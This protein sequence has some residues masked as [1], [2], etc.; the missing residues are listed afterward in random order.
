MGKDTG[1]TGL[2]PADFMPMHQ[3]Q[4]VYFPYL[5]MGELD[6]IDLGFLKVWNFDLKK[7]IYVK[8]AT[9]LA[10]VEKIIATHVTQYGN[11]KGIGI[12]QMP[13]KGFEP[14]NDDEIELV[15]QARAILFLMATSANN[16]KIADGNSGHSM[17]TSENFDAIYQNFL[18]TDDYVS[19]SAGE[20][21]PFRKGGNTLQKIR[22][23]IPNFVPT[24]HRYGLDQEMQVALSRIRSKKPKVFQRIINSTQIFIEGYYNSPH[25]SSKA[26]VLMIMS[27]FEMIFS[28][29][30]QDMRKHF[31]NKIQSIA[32]LDGDKR[33]MNYWKSRA[34]PKSKESLSKKGL[35]AEKFYLL[36]NKITHGDDVTK[37][38]FFFEKKQPHIYIAL[39]FFILAIKKQF[40]KSLND[41]TCNYEIKW[42]TYLDEISFDQ[43]RKVTK[44]VYK[45]SRRKLFQKLLGK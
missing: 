7:D 33:Y 34:Y 1:S 3:Y 44:F 35:W 22:F 2:E 23:Q 15:Q 32:D 4:I 39:L 27:A 17:V 37:T 10:K 36:R 26:R 19:E 43:P 42:E 6:E 24:P 45:Y 11:V 9:L 20:I 29:P 25:L 18:L 16:T 41:F 8:D 38:D 40:E 12:V 21:I 14:L 5:S 30:E 13:N 31:K 28:L